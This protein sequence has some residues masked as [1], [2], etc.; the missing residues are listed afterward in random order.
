MAMYKNEIVTVFCHLCAV[1]EIQILFCLSLCDV[2]KPST[3]VLLDSFCHL[4]GYLY[5]KVIF[6][7]VML[8]FGLLSNLFLYMN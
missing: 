7:F 8:L 4:N 1:I 5:V 2:T 6:I 3:A